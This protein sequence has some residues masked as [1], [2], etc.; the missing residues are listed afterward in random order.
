MERDKYGHYV[1][2]EKVEI[3]TST[4]K[5][6]RNHIDVY[7]SCPAENP[8]HRSIHVNYDS[9]NGKGSIVDTTSGGKETTDVSCYLT[10]ACM[11]C[12]KKEFND[13]CDELTTLRW[14]RDQFVSK[15]D[16]KHYYE[17]APIIVEIIN[18][19]ENNNEIYNNIYEKVV[20]A[21]VEA[22]KK[23]DF[24]FAYNRYKESVLFFEDEYVRPN[25][26]NRLIKVLKNNYN[27]LSKKS[28]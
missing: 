11:R 7:D 6:G 25:L 10:T 18:N 5:Y 13:N 12:L 1:N 4:D 17:I 23:D 9:D 19:L 20:I 2:N 15:D 28:N 26:E 24:E 21:C 3:R 8:E 16:I 22:I 27:Q 14:F